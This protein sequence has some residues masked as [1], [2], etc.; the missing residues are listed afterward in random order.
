MMQGPIR[1]LPRDRVERRDDAQ[2]SSAWVWVDRPA[3]IL[4]GL[5]WLTHGTPTPFRTDRGSPVLVMLGSND[6]AV[7]KELL[8]HATA[9]SRVY[10][11][12]PKEWEAKGVHQELIYASKVL[13]RRV[14]EVPASAI[15]TAN[16][17]RL[18]LGGS[19]SL[20]LDDTQSAALR[21][22]FLRLF[23]HDAIEEAW[24]GG[25]QLLWRVAA[26]RPFDVPDVSRNAPVRLVGSD[27]RLEIDMRGALVHLTGGSLPDATPRKLWFP[28]GADH[29]DRLAKLVR[30][31]AE[32]VWDDR[33]LP[34]FAIGANG[35]EVLLPGTRAR[36]SVMLMPEQT[37][38]VTRI[39][40]A[41]ARWNFGVDVRIGDPALRS[42]KFWLA[43]EKG[44]R[45]IEA[46][47]PI[48]VADVMANSL[49]AVPD[50]SPA[51]WPAA[52]P[53][54]LSVRYRWTVVPPRILA[55]S[56]ED[57]LI[58]RWRKIDEEWQ[59]SIIS[60]RQTL[61]QVEDKQG[62]IA[63]K[64]LSRLA[65]A[66][67]GFG[68]TRQGLLDQLSSM[69]QQRP[70]VVGP[71]SARDMLSELAKVAERARQLQGDVDEA[72]RKAQEDDAR[73]QQ[74][75]EHRARV[76]EA[77]R[78]VPEKKS[79]LADAEAQLSKLQAEK[80]KVDEAKKTADKEALKDL[81]ARQKKLF[82]EIK[83]ANKAVTRIGGELRDAEQRAA[84]K[85]DFRLP[86]SLTPRQKQGNAGRFVPNASTTRPESNVPN[87]ALPE[88]GAL[89]LHKNQRYLVIHDWED[90]MQ[91]EQA[92]ER[93]E[94][95]LVAPENV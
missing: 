75:R 79:E 1:R 64:L 46:E 25:K 85:F 60:V 3:T 52:Q 13:I 67:L 27:A 39:L 83:L 59:S 51:T 11:L 74:E 88:V 12:V 15:Q 87:Q 56:S 23:W 91:G 62:S 5:T 24:T 63:S 14:P 30:D 2:L 7:F 44:A 36:M 65:G 55:G 45:D 16:G 38:D 78:E 71:S 4:P 80:T 53:L 34:D 48:P 94:A 72:E 89:R 20:R 84:E 22:V 69:Q 31:R 73:D 26:E 54:A 66:L 9:G 77:E 47:Q 40:E 50:S 70:S 33:G 8:D 21:R 35:A 41:P 82:D 6:D 92:A 76:E 43:G 17:S 28:A 95:M 90:L 18:W 93:L 42:A 58:G 49:R 29:H 32:V 81:E 37:A 10:V 57:P 61:T 68:R 19:W 86:P